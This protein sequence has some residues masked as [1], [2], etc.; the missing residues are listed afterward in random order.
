[1]KC[2]NMKL[3]FG[4][5]ALLLGTQFPTMVHGSCSGSAKSCGSST[6]TDIADCREIDG[7]RVETS[8]GYTECINTSSDQATSSTNCNRY[9]DDA[10]DCLFSGCTFRGVQE[11]T[12]CSG[13]SSPCSS[14]QVRSWCTSQPG[15]YWTDDQ[16]PPS[17]SSTT[18]SS[19][20]S[21][22]D[23][24]VIVG[25]VV[26]FLVVVGVAVTLCLWRNRKKKAQ[27]R[28]DTKTD[29]KDD[30]K[31]AG[32]PSDLEKADA[33]DQTDFVDLTESPAQ[34]ENK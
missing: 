32:A 27:A 20:K 4:S 5:C 7:C 14:F 29:A 25:P 16:G 31:K 26:G 12:Y 34:Q 15:C 21:S 17:P 6:I 9:S 3:A 18:K 24:G 2:K 33:V 8:S 10:A 28:Q 19:D 11:K 23:H 13:S 22:P 1:M 30:N